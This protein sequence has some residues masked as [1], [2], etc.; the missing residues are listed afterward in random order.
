MFVD[1]RLSGTTPLVLSKVSAGSH[2]V[3]VER[4]GYRRWSIRIHV[5]SGRRAR[6]TASLEPE[7]SR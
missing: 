5:A 7:S 2:D 1:G 6:L 3:R 4:A